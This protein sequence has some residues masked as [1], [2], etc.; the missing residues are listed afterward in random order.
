MNTLK[1]PFRA[2]RF[3]LTSSYPC[4]YLPAHFARN[5]V[6]DPEAIDNSLYSFLATLGFRRSGNYIY[7]PHCSSCSECLSLRIPVAAFRR[8]RTQQRTWD[9]N[10]DLAVNC[11]PPGFE[12]EHYKLFKRYLQ[13]RHAEGGMEDTT[14]EGYLSFITSSWSDT[15][16]HEFRLGSRLLAVAVTDHLEDGLSAV[17]TYFDPEESARSLGTYAILW[18]IEEAKRRGLQ[19]VYL[20]Y[21]VKD[22]GK[23]AY[24]A[25]FQPHQ[26]FTF[27][28]WIPPPSA[29]P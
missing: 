17:Y 14:P 7:R 23:M 9:R 15:V 18:Q 2:L 11:E 27:G 6:V 1:D 24:K 26:I 8:S 29:R 10:R 20:G 22:C 21:W 13:I 16:L 12:F 5:L 4:S 19:C 28:K 3:F 25:N